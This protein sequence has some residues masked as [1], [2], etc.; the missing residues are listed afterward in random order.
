V[1]RPSTPKQELLDH[2]IDWH[3]PGPYSF[4]KANLVRLRG[5]HYELH[6][7]F[8]MKRRHHTHAPGEF[9]PAVQI[10]SPRYRTTPQIRKAQSLRAALHNLTI[11]DNV[12][13]MTTATGKD[14]LSAWNRTA[15]RL[16]KGL[17]FTDAEDR[18]T[19]RGRFAYQTTNLRVSTIITL[20]QDWGKVIPANSSRDLA[21]KAATAAWMIRRLNQQ[22]HRHARTRLAGSET[23]VGERYRSV[24]KATGTTVVLVSCVEQGIPVSDGGRWAVICEEHGS[25]IQDDIQENLR[26]IMAEPHHWCDACVRKDVEDSVSASE[27]GA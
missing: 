27:L 25:L 9:E 3:T 21:V 16:A 15:A 2:L 17:D 10:R 11:L 1:A 4:S 12:P 7:K 8:E 24:A 20:A 14:T 23:L 18:A 22:A 13:P 26:Q 6:T 19:F 5:M